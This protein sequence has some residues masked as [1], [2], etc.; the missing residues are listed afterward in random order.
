MPRKYLTDAVKEGL[1]EE[2]LRD[3]CVVV[4]GED[5]EIGSYPW[6]A[7]LVDEFGHSRVRN[8]PISEVTIMG[9]GLGSAICGLRP[10]VDIMFGNFFYTGM[11]QL[12]NQITKLRYMTGGQFEVPAVFIATMGGGTNIAAQ[13]SDTP[14]PVFMNLG[15]A[16]IVVP[17][18]PYDAKGL[19]KTAIRDNNPVLFLIPLVLIGVKG[20][21]PDEEYFIPFGVADIKQEGTDITLVAVGSMVKQALKAAKQLEKEGI[22]TEVIDP[23]TI[24]PF[25]EKT[26]LRSLAK[27]GRMVVVDEAREFC[28]VASEIAAIAVEKGFSSLKAPVVRVTVPNVPIPFSPPL[29]NFVIPDVGK[30]VKAVYKVMDF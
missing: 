25:D 1:H 30:I 17:T 26:I 5:V 9:M 3:P 28:S 8:T 4:L 27:T 22:S 14:Y 15:G 6:T 24:I 13:H 23:R 12:A 7:G 10:V 16:R 21:V 18:T 29:E 20:E 19:L 11:D 2:M